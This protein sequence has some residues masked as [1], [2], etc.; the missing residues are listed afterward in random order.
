MKSAVCA[1]VALLCGS[2][3]AEPVLQNVVGSVQVNS[4]AAK[5]GD[6]VPAGASIQTGGGSRAEVRFDDGHLI[7]LGAGTQ[8]QLRQYAY[9]KAEP[10][11]DSILMSLLVGTLRS[12]TGALGARNPGKFSLST[13]TATAGIRGTDFGVAVVPAQATASW[14]AGG[15]QVAGVGSIPLDLGDAALAP[16]QLAQIPIPSVFFTVNTGSIGVVTSSASAIMGAGQAVAI[17]VG[18]SVSFVSAAVLPGSLSSMMSTPLASGAAGAGAQGGA[19]AGQAGSGTAGASSGSAG[20]GTG[21]G[22]GAGA[23]AGTGASA[24]AGAGAAGATTA[25]TGAVTGATVAVGAA[26]AAVVVTTVG[27]TTG[28]SGTT[29]TT[30]TQ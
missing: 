17:G 14:S 26:A 18:G 24:G 6:A 20:A 9:S 27:S 1:A 21:A 2:V 11:K 10:A 12:I 3:W 5:V 28:T 8:F 19:S 23:G 4:K 29:G 13:P 25:A 30:G 7:A 16:L 15:V 22:T